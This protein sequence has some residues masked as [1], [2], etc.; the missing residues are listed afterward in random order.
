MKAVSAYANWRA[1]PSQPNLNK[2]QQ[3]V[4]KKAET[5]ARR[6]APTAPVNNGEIHIYAEHKKDLLRLPVLDP[7]FIR[8][9]DERRT[10]PKTKPPY[11][12][13]FAKMFGEFI[14]SPEDVWVRARKTFGTKKMEI[15]AMDATMD[16]KI[17]LAHTAIEQIF[18]FV[19]RE[20]RK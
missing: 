15:G 1:K 16:K 5:Q 13:I 8:A 3:A 12:D 7:D 18:V 4:I 19:M 10:D 17:A 14:R 11:Q 2:P 6:P 9:C 20:K